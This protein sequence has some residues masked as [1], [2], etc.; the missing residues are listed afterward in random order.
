MIEPNQLA[1][2]WYLK[3][4]NEWV[5]RAELEDDWVPIAKELMK[6]D[7]LQYELSYWS[8]SLRKGKV[9]EAH[10]LGVMEIYKLRGG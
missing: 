7:Y 2:A 8:E 9:T 6:N 3:F 1:E 4:G 10:S 5:T